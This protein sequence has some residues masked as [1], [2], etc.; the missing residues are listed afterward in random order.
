M[1]F[2]VHNVGLPIPPDGLPVVFEP[3]ARGHGQVA[4]RSIG[5]GLFIALGIVSAHG[6]DIQVS[7][8]ADAG[9]PFTVTFTLPKA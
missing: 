3:L 9:T 8:S 2:A 7:S 5:L 1:K 6:G 4:G